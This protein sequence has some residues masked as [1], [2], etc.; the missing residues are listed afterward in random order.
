MK[1]DPR[2]HRL[3]WGH[4]RGLAVS[5]RLRRSL[6]GDATGRAASLLAGTIR[7]CGD[8]LTRH[9]QAE[10]KLLLPAI[11]AAGR[12]ADPLVDRMRREHTAIRADIAGLKRVR[13]PGGQGSHEA[14]RAREDARDALL[15][16]ASD[17]TSHIRF[18]ERVLFPWIESWLPGD[19][20]D[21]VGRA[22]ERALA[23]ETCTD[24]FPDAPAERA[25]PSG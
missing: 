3:S 23:F 10:E 13:I 22:L 20:F 11:E 9:F 21:R 8:E 1:R 6:S 24:V 19:A 25:D 2:L 14:R 16:L 7:F 17:L 5:L 4:Q 15:R 12:G 18:E